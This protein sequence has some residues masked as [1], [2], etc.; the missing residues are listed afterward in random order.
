MKLP[1]RFW[2]LRWLLLYR[3]TYRANSLCLGIVQMA[4]AST[5]LTELFSKYPFWI[6]W[7]KHLNKF[8]NE[9]ISSFLHQLWHFF[10]L[11]QL[12]ELLLYLPEMKWIDTYFKTRWIKTRNS[13]YQTIKYMIKN[14]WIISDFSKNDLHIVH[15]F[16]ADTVN[17]ITN[18]FDVFNYI[19]IKHYHPWWIQL[20]GNERG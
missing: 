1:K 9:Y 20:I 7:T 13:T 10:C 3:N 16:L 14:H 2:S 18:D 5:K 8:R 15:K 4:I 6:W 17:T 11:E 12:L 19:L